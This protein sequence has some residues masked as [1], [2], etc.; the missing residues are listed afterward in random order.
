[1]NRLTQ[2]PAP[3]AGPDVLGF[4]ALDF[5]PVPSMVPTARP[6]QTP[7]AYPLNAPPDGYPLVDFHVG[8]N[9][10][11]FAERGQQAMTENRTTVRSTF[12]DDQPGRVNPP[13]SGILHPPIAQ[14]DFSGQ[15]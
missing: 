7:M 4:Q 1:M 10:D 13:R 11:A 3:T 12:P 15:A 2:H 14:P 5:A 9:T 8:L 6:D